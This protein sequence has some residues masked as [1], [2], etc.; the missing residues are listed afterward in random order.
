MAGC[1]IESGRT[2]TCHAAKITA[3]ELPCGVIEKGES[4]LEAAKREL[5]EKTGYGGGEWREPMAAKQT[6]FPQNQQSRKM[7]TV[8][9]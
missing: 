6:G 3:Y 9:H 4:P 2:I 5:A 7:L 1:G 8:G